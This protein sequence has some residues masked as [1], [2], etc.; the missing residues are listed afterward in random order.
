MLRSFPPRFL[1]VGR[2]AGGT[3][4][5]RASGTRSRRNL[6]DTTNASVLSGMKS[7]LL[8]DW[9]NMHLSAKDRGR[10]FDAGALLRL[11]RARV[12]GVL[13]VLALAAREPTLS[14]R[15]ARLA[16]QGYQVLASRGTCVGG[17]FK[18]DADAA[19]GAL[20][21]ALVLRT[22]VRQ[23]VLAT[24]DGDFM[25]MIAVLRRLVGPEL[26]VVALGVE[27]CFS[28]Q[29]K[30]AADASAVLGKDVLRAPGRV[31][32]QARSPVWPRS[33]A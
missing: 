8:V 26:R 15:A 30:A 33:A 19:L 18:A 23:L 11:V 10:R 5:A 32:V 6:P 13:P 27:G 16:G 21:A 14:E 31:E 12:P 3:A 28:R 25:P 7:G 1:E 4:P 9:N 22:R 24:G 20:A 2:A 17:R 29:L